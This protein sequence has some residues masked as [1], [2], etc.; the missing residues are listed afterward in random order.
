MTPGILDALILLGGATATAL[1]WRLSWRREA[2]R[3]AAEG[4]ARALAER[5]AGHHLCFSTLE[6]LAC[7]IEAANPAEVGHLDS[8]QQ[9]VTA[10][11]QALS[12]PEEEAAAT[13]AAALLHNIGR[14]GIPPYILHKTDALTPEE[15]EKLR[16]Q[17]LLGA[18]I[19]AS[20]PFPWHVVPLVRH[21]TE[22]WDGSGYPD[23][24]QGEAIPRGARIL[25][26]ANIYSALQRAGPLGPACSPEQAL[27]EIAARAGDQL[28]PHLVAV[29]Q[30]IARPWDA[31]QQVN[32]LTV[33]GV[34][35]A[36]ARRER[37]APLALTPDT[38]TVLHDIAAA[39]RE[40]LG[41]FSLAQTVTGSLHLEAVART[42]LESTRD[43]VPCAACALFL[44]ED[45]GEFL[46]A[47]AALG[48]NERHLLGSLACVGTHL[49]GRAFSRAEMIRAPFTPDDLVLRDVSDPWIPFRSLLVVPLLAGGLP[50][51]TLNLYAEA[52]DAFDLDSRRVMRLV[53]TQAARAIDNARRYAAAQETARTDALTG[54]KNARFL[55]EY[56]D[57]E[58]NRAERE[59]S[60]MAVLNIDL[61]NF[62]PIND[63]FG[64]ARGDQTLREVAEILRSHVRSYDLA[65][66]YAGDE[67]V[68]VL[69][70]AGRV[71]AETAAQK[72]RA[73]I[74]RHGQKLMAR[75][76]GFPP[77]AISVGIALYP[78][79]GADIQGLLCH[80]DA[81]MYADKHSRRQAA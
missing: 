59:N 76:P 13:R 53:A 56:L 81:A 61:D 19:L 69:A 72:L 50:I 22:H 21:Y 55:R 42:V 60:A 33:S 44:P 26:I 8:V 15:Q 63:T 36:P 16:C 41:L 48:L 34:E 24:L 40:T 52:P 70:R 65:A 1:G 43:I 67:F 4:E 7:A 78:R 2:Q 71:E 5:A 17:P 58:I 10:L 54:L 23:G 14:L 75:E 57:R 74:E 68:V 38:R 35:T 47:H 29:F 25:A 32:G 31:A 62:K 80:S 46:Q 37:P 39:Q 73:A 49:T 9:G 30:G 28:D 18:R 66:R 3:L 51:G 27:A 11:S 77:L 79:D 12:L 45:N 6:A 64:H 20:I